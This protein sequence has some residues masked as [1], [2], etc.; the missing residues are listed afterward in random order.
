[1]WKFIK[2]FIVSPRQTGA[3]LPSGP[4]LTEAMLTPINFSEALHIVELG[5]GTGAFTHQILRKMR[6]D[7]H[8]TVIE[9]NKEF[10]KKMR[11]IKDKRL[12]IIHG[13]AAKL[14]LHVKSADYIISGLPLVSLPA[15]KRDIILQEIKKTVK[16]RYVQFHYSPLA[17]KDIKK[18]FKITAKKNIA[19]NIP[20]AIVYVCRKE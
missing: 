11:D 8:L 19:R 4:A 5:P 6:P 15:T 12:T 14:S 13:D 9:V 7:A 10:I 17:E 18:H 3:I 1:M 16:N 20:P 2:E